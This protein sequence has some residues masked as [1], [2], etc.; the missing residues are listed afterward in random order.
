MPE[1]LRNFIKGLSAHDADKLWEWLDS[2]ALAIEEM[3]AV[4]AEQGVRPK[5]SKTNDQR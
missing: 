1:L 2:N 5:R 4:A 3:I